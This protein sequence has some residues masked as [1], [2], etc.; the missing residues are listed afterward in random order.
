MSDRW[1]HISTNCLTWPALSHCFHRFPKVVM[2]WNVNTVVLLFLLFSTLTKQTLLSSPSPFPLPPLP[3]FTTKLW[4]ISKSW[5]LRRSHVQS[6]RARTAHNAVALRKHSTRAQGSQTTQSLSLRV[7]GTRFFSFLKAR[8]YHF[9][10][11]LFFF[12]SV[13]FG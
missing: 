6:V 10:P 8:A 7:H 1:S 4:K 3:S 9:F 5:T 13:I 11:T 12:L 2:E